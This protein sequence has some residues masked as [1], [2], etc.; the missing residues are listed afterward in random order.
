MQLRDATLPTVARRIDVPTYDRSRLRP[1]VVHIGV[2]G[3]HRAHQAVYLDALA[4]SGDLSWGEVGVGLRSTRLRD[5]LV[6]QDCLWTV[7][8]R[9]TGAESAYVVGAMRGYLHGP[10]DPAAVLDRLADPQTRLVTLTVTGDGYNLDDGG[11]F[12]SD[13]P[14]V[15]GDLQSGRAPATWFGYVVAALARRRAHGLG[16]FTVLSCDN[17]PDS[18]AAAR[19]AVVSYARMRDETLALWI[20][21]NVTFPNSM[22]DRITP[23]ADDALAQQLA[24]VYGVVDRAPVLTEPFRQWIIEDDF[25][26]GRPPLERLGVQFVSDVAPYKLTKT[27]LLNGTHT[28]MA[29]LGLLAGHQTTAGMVG[30][31][32]M[33]AY[34]SR[35]MQ[36]EIAPLLPPAPG[37]ELKRYGSTVLQR[38]A[39]EQ[40]A[41]PLTRLSDRGSTKMPS[42]LLPS[43]VETRREGRSAPLITLAVAAWIRCLRGTDLLGGPLPLRDARLDELQP[44]ARR[45]RTDVSALLGERSIM[46]AL[47]DDLVVRRELGRA[48]R[49]LDRSGV[50]AATRSRLGESRHTERALIVQQRSVEQSSTGA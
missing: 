22:V 28:A 32:T 14:V 15:I 27:R 39:N 31:P 26:N 3:F 34:L 7:V 33:R 44:L 38:L 8:E 6:P 42:Y 48:L 25:C 16:G 36:E 24:G 47:S 2:G 50:R 46:G 41:D 23:A 40:I 4:R 10:D 45:C 43:L 35:L 17:L 1:A 11:G 49:D 20:E 29:Y 30:D 37:M 21:R 19:T 13:D 12:R 9:T 18:G 5:A